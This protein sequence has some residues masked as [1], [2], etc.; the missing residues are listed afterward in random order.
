MNIDSAIERSEVE[1][2]DHFITDTLRAF[3]THLLAR[4]KEEPV[5]VPDKYRNPNP[6]KFFKVYTDSEILLVH[7]MI[8]EGLINCVIK[9]KRPLLIKGSISQKGLDYLFAE[10]LLEL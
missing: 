2:A 4:G 10:K 8:N 1:R 9:E 6:L 7:Y 5:P 3:Y